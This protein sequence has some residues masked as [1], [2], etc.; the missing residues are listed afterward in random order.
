MHYCANVWL[1]ALKEVVHSHYVPS[2][3]YSRLSAY[4]GTLLLQQDSYI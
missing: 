4:S 2:D 1:V 3:G